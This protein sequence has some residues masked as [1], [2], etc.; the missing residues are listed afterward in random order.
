MKRLL[1]LIFSLLSINSF[2]QEDAWIFF[3]DKPNAQVFYDNPSLMLSPR[4]LLRRTTQ[5]IA[6]DSKDV[7]LHQPYVNQIS[8]ATGITVLAKSKWL[9]AL[10]IQG[11]QENISALTA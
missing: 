5:N 3:N 7:P 4:A 8:T 2:S 6:I 1:L 11:P 10:H 9:N